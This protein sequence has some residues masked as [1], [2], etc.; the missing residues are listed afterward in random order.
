MKD[1]VR[2][3]PLKARFKK[4]LKRKGTLEGDLS[5]RPLVKSALGGR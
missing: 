3:M 5:I 2:V 1:G 4:Q